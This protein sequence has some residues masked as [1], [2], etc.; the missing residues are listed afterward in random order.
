M[1]NRINTLR[2]I[3]QGFSSFVSNHTPRLPDMHLPTSL[4]LKRGLLEHRGM[5]LGIGLAGLALSACAVNPASVPP[6]PQQ[7]GLKLL[8]EANPFIIPQYVALGAGGVA[9]V[10]TL[11]T[12]GLKHF[13][14]AADVTKHGYNYARALFDTMVDTAADASTAAFAGG[15]A[16]LLAEVGI[17]PKVIEIIQSQLSIIGMAG[18]AVLGLNM[19]DKINDLV[20]LV[21][22]PEGMGQNAPEDDA[23]E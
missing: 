14:K 10:S 8:V 6:V 7:D 22:L 15:A 13:Q 4:E 9:G 16:V 12:E 17:S 5:L 3:S 1:S 19:F 20:G 2:G 18:L 23:Q 21:R 11:I